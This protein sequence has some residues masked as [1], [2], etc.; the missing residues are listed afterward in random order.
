MAVGAERAR[1][2]L[3]REDGGVRVEAEAQV[4]LDEVLSR[5]AQIKGVPVLKLAAHLCQGLLANRA[6]ARQLLAQ[7]DV[8]PHLVGHVLWLD[9]AAGGARLAVHVALLQHVRH[10]VVGH[11]DGRI[12]ERLDEEVLVPRHARA[13]TK[14]PRA[15]PLLQPSKARNKLVLGLVAVRLQL[16][17]RLARQR[18]P[19]ILAIRQVP[20]V[21]ERHHAI[22]ARARHDGLLRFAVQHG[23]P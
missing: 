1:P 10:R 12:G 22:I 17:E 16:I 8:V 21:G 18:A 14:G 2:V 9:R 23:L 11:V 7:E 13:Q 15:R 6:V 3:A 4:V 20:L 5:H 19:L